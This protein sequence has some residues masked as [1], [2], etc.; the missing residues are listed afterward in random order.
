[1][2]PEVIVLLC[3]LALIAIWAFGRLL[4]ARERS[5][6]AS[7]WKPLLPKRISSAV[8][9][10]VAAVIAPP[11]LTERLSP[12]AQAL[13]MECYRGIDRSKLLDYHT[14]L[15]GTGGG[16]CESGC[17]IPPEEDRDLKL[18]T[19]STVFMKCAGVRSDETGDDDFV[20]MLARIAHG[21]VS[22]VIY[23]EIFS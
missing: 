15:F 5:K 2:E 16:C 17:E 23:L 8:A 22:G 7:E 18:Q 3:V 10:S 14:H 21:K 11:L 6:L 20:E 13:V 12:A 9:N 19:V 1:M 4:R